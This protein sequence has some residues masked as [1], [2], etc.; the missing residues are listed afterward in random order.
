MRSSVACDQERSEKRP[1]D[2]PS[3]LLIEPRARENRGSLQLEFFNRIGHVQT[4]TVMQSLTTA[5]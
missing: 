4:L 3:E 1:D 2:L 5:G